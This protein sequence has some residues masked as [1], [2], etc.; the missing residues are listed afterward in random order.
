MS[1]KAKKTLVIGLGG[2]G[3]AVVS[4]VKRMVN[5]MQLHP[6]PDIQF[7][8]FDTDKNQEDAPD[9]DIVL[10]STKAK[11]GEMLRNKHHQNWQ[12]WFPDNDSMMDEDMLDGAGQKRVLSRL[13]FSDVIR[14][15]TPLKVLDDAIKKLTLENGNPQDVALKVMVVS[16]FAGGTGAGM[17]MQLPLYLRQKYGE[18]DMS[19]SKITI[20]GLFALPDVFLSSAR[21]DEVQQESMY[22]NAYASLKE[23]AAINMI[24]LSKNPAMRKYTMQIDS[25]FDSRRMFKRLDERGEDRTVTAVGKKPYDF[26]FFVDNQNRNQRVLGDKKDYLDLMTRLTYMQ[27]YSPLENR[28]DSREDNLIETRMESDGE[29]M[30]GSAGA[31]R[32]VYP[33][34]DIAQYCALRA[35]QDVLN[36]KWTKFDRDY[37]RQLAVAKENRK[38]DTTMKLPLRSASYITGVENE[39]KERSAA[40]AFLRSAV[41]DLVTPADGGNSID[42]QPEYL[43]EQERVPEYVGKV[44]LHINELIQKD[45]QLVKELKKCG[46]YKKILQ[47]TKWSKDN[48]KTN[49]TVAE[50]CL[51]KLLEKIEE[52][53]NAMLLYAVDSIIPDDLSLLDRSAMKGHQIFSILEKKN[54]NGEA[55][56]V[57]PLAVRYLLYRIRDMISD[58]LNGGKDNGAVGSRKTMERC[59][60]DTHTYQN[61]D[62]KPS[63][64]EKEKAADVIGERGFAYLDVQN[65]FYRAYR[66]QLSNL[67]KYMLSRFQTMVYTELLEKLNAM[68]LY[69]ERVFDAI[70]GVEKDIQNDIENLKNK[71]RYDAPDA[72]YVCASEEHMEKIYQSTTDDTEDEESSSIYDELLTSVYEGAMDILEYEE[73][74]RRE[75]WDKKKIKEYDAINGGKNAYM[76]S[77]IFTTQIIPYYKETLCSKY[78]DL[79]DMNICRALRQHIE[80]QLKREREMAGNF[81]PILQSDIDK[82]RSEILTAVE[83]KAAPYLMSVDY[84]T[85][86]AKL[87]ADTGA[88]STLDSVYWGLHV[89][90]AKDVC[91]E[92]GKKNVDSYFGTTASFSSDVRAH[93]AYS[94]YA[95]DCY[96]GLYSVRLTE[97]P[98]FR[99]DADNMGVF[100]AN[101]QAR[102]DKMNAGRY[103]EPDL[104]C[105]PHLDIRWH[106]RQYLPMI[107]HDKDVFDDQNAARAMWLSFLYGT[108]FIK[109]DP[110]SGAKNVWIRYWR[111]RPGKP[112]EKYFR[113][114]KELLCNGKNVGMNQ[115]FE[116]FKAFQQDARSAKMMLETLE[117]LLSDDCTATDYNTDFTGKNANPLAQALICMKDAAAEEVSAEEMAEYVDFGNSVKKENVLDLLNA[118]IKNKQADESEKQMIA[119]ELWKILEQYSEAMSE[120]R[121]QELLVHILSNSGYASARNRSLTARNLMLDEHFGMAM[122]AYDAKNK[123]KAAKAK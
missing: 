51:E 60:A 91:N 23:L 114:Q 86:N 95:Y 98:K 80:G 68:I 34:E 108:L 14:R 65:K 74:K 22:A 87:G 66:N 57:H 50:M 43:V 2:T 102:I 101:Y 1:E 96:R 76:V 40:F 61:K 117:T 15:K 44:I 33:Y 29:A 30:Y 97:I 47:K 78:A 46:D 12:E 49:V 122:A 93:Q 75:G 89:D 11:V 81:K 7:V 115:V 64:P 19:F 42:G 88:A 84:H 77:N 13:A 109:A 106:S 27:V 104:A 5:E 121:F 36:G 72:V 20:R 8:G 24:C 90:V 18:Q 25:L 10:T 48:A 63:T 58:Q 56:A 4:A 3:C 62:Y 38:K 85:P 54:E 112:V 32:L 107:G 111:M 113:E 55:S 6:D 31:A 83:T 110:K 70:V 9:L 120:A 82:R 52:R 103:D 69:F 116:V 67:E 45:P 21:Y 39:L 123:K 41:Y 37:D 73:T 94:R 92:I 71:Y 59:I 118:V 79:L 35:T 53:T 26:I 100:Y 119:D 105:T 99:E 16:S 28:L 17:F